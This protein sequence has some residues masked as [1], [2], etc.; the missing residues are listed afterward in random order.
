MCDSK[1]SDRL[2][3]ENAQGKGVY[4]GGFF[5]EADDGYALLCGAGA[6]RKPVLHAHVYIVSL[7]PL[8]KSGKAD[9]GYEKHIAGISEPSDL[10]KK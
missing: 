1:L 4:A 5:A 3:F 10:L 9:T 6:R 8:Q 2:L 7:L